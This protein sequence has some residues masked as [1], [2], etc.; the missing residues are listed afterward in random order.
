MFLLVAI[1]II[2]MIFSGI[3]NCFKDKEIEENNCPYEVE[4]EEKHD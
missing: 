2:A 3:A 4:G 1:M